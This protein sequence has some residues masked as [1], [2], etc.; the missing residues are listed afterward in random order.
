MKEHALIVRAESERAM[1]TV[2]STASLQ[3]AVIQPETAP[4]PSLRAAGEAIQP[5]SRCAAGLLRSTRKD[6]AGIR[7]QQP[8]NLSSMRKA[9]QAGCYVSKRVSIV[10]V[11]HGRH[12]RARF[13]EQ[14]ANSTFSDRQRDGFRM[15]VGSPLIIAQAAIPP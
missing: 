5:F 4:H 12:A 6:E 15:A 7:E 10:R 2:L 1:C 13:S 9:G 11:L 14:H 8:R 3:T